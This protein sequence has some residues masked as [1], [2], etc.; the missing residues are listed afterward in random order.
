M[1]PI[2]WLLPTVTDQ[3]LVRNSI[4]LSEEN[5]LTKA[6]ETIKH[7]HMDEVLLGEIV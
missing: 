6:K 3:L 5:L 4:S 1:V 7:L 2:P